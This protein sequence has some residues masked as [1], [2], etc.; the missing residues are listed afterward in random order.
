M[1]RPWLDNYP[2]DVPKTL[3]P[4]PEE[5]LFG[6][7]SKAASRHPDRPAITFFGKRMSYAQLL[8]ET[9]RFSSVLTGLGVAKGDRVALI[10]PNCPQYVIA[11]YA[12]VRVGATVVGN[13]P[14]YT[15]REMAHQL[16]DCAPRVTV[17]LENFYR[18][19]SSVMKTVD[20]GEVLVTK[21]TDYMPFPINKLAPIKFKK[22]AKL[23]SRPWPYVPKG[24]EVRWWKRTMKGAGPPLPPA[25]VEARAE[26]AGF[27]YTGG[28]TGLAKGAMLSHYNITAN[29][30]Q[31]ASWF[32]DIVDGQDV[33]MCVL[34]FFH[35]FGMMAMNVAIL[36][37][38]KLILVPR[39]D[40]GLVLKA[41]EKEKPTHFP[42]VPRLYIAL[43]ESPETS[44]HDLSSITACISGGA[45]LPVAVA[46]RFREVTG[47]AEVVEGYGLTETSPVAVANP[48]SG[49]R[50]PG[51]I[52]IPLPDTDCKIVSLEEPDRAVGQ[53]ES[54]ELCLRGPQ[55]M[56][57][58]W[59]RPDETANSIRD[60]WFHTG[61]V[62]VMDEQGY[63]KIV[64]RLKD[65]VLVSGF[66]VYPTEI[67][68]VLYHHPKILKAC[69]VGVP[70]EKT[71]E[72]IKAF[73]VLREGETATAEEI[74]QWCRDPAQGLT[75]YR[76]PKQI[77][78]RESLP[79]TMIGKVLRRV[80]Q[81]EEKQKRATGAGS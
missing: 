21:L 75:G 48:L 74:S 14:L 27:I 28:T 1:D 2:S 60:G 76:V 67:E 42:G 63:F 71:G 81:E 11:Y 33:M 24:V 10:L 45:P 53:G 16:G 26:P 46:D 36:K 65:M 56:L 13:N 6:I 9:E 70:D 12:A 72:A 43:N 23:E 32:P 55:V 47:G 19:L 78:F 39:F 57:G 17:T 66:N 41:I 22:E 51:H 3:G 59:N 54:G 34:P 50:K 30:M 7:L 38:M 8:A 62:A 44:K 73:I 18:Q 68:A 61:D 79:E 37:A 35:S 25:V 15:E 49:V 64:D 20:V 69:V 40:I 5:S 58:Y 4:Y 31:S 77:E 80:L 29:A 52:G